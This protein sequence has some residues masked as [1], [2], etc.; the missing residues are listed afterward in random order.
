MRVETFTVVCAWCHRVVKRATADAL[1]SHTICPTCLEWTLTH[2][3]SDAVRGTATI[4][5]RSALPD[6]YFGDAFKQ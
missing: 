2:S 6:G 4:N 5:D 1:V 3:G